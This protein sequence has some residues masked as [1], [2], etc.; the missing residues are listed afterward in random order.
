MKRAVIAVAL[1]LSAC[2]AKTP[3]VVP[4]VDP[5]PSGSVAPSPEPSKTAAVARVAVRAAFVGKEGLYLYDVKADTV[6]HLLAGDGIMQPRFL[7]RDTVAFLRD[8]GTGSAV[9]AYNIATQALTTLHTSNATIGAWAPRPDNEE[10]AYVATDANAYPQ[11]RYRALVGN[12]ST[13]VVTTLARALGRGTELSEQRLVRWS[14]DARRTLVVY[15]PADGDEHPVP[16]SAAQLQVRGADGR[17][18]FAPPQAQQATQATMSLDGR[19]IYYRSSAGTRV[20]DA[21]TDTTASVPGRPPA[22]FNPTPSIDG[23][24]LA[25]D[26][27]ATTEKVRVE[28][29]DVRSGARRQVGP[30][31]RIRPIY[32][33]LRT[34]WTQTVIPCTGECLTSVTPGTEVFATDLRNGRERKLALTSLQDLAVFYA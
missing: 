19:R 16:D 9:I 31:G 25:Y 4:T 24:M 26:T 15:T 33:D 7:N 10:I 23:H 14:P 17:L 32:A 30:T 21:A 5:S 22:W 13:L 8:E 28:T 12:Q 34:L 20:W 3:I 2:P 18:E 1:V 27:G 29:I 6:Q 11:V